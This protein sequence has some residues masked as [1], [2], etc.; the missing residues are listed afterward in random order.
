MQ[1]VIIEKWT[2]VD[3]HMPWL[4]RGEIRE[5]SNEVQQLY[6]DIR[7]GRL[8]IHTHADDG[9]TTVAVGTYRDTGKSVHLRGA[10]R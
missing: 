2:W 4:T 1:D 3:Y 9:Q 6:D 7:L 8:I 5:V 10:Q